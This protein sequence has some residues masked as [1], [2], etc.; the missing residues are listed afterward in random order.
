MKTFDAIV[1][2]QISGIG[3]LILGIIFVF[4]VCI[5]I[6]GPRMFT[7]T[8]INS[9]AKDNEKENSKDGQEEKS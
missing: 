6:V 7:I 1:D 9:F 4:V 5:V 3:M 2:V 8:A